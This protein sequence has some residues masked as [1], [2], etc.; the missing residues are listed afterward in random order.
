M[1]RKS[2]PFARAGATALSNK[3]SLILDSHSYRY[4]SIALHVYKIHSSLDLRGK[5]SLRLRKLSSN[6]HYYRFRTNIGK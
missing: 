6:F 4:D 1:D 3:L 2:S 5:Q